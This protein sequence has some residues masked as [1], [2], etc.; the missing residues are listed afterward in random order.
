LD[1]CFAQIQLHDKSVRNWSITYDQLLCM[2][3][4]SI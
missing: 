1:V 3:F 4:C 2:L